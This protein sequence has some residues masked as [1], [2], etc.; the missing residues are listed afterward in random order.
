M[1]WGMG[2]EVGEAAGGEAQDF[3]R[4]LVK[5]RGKSSKVGGEGGREARKSA[6]HGGIHGFVYL[7]SFLPCF[8]CLFRPPAHFLS[9]GFGPCSLFS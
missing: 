4:T 3:P 7:L 9:N 5:L 8:L 6:W 2:E 1:R